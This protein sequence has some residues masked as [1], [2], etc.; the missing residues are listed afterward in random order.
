MR[1]VERLTGEVANALFCG[2]L[3]VVL[4]M[5]AG[6]ATGLLS[7]ARAERGA[8]YAVAYRP[9]GKVVASAGFDGVVRL[10]DAQTGK[11]LQ[12]FIPYPRKPSTLTTSVNQ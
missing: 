8:V 4:P 1:S 12:E 9:D 3:A 6:L 5:L 11:L 10:N 7:P 2:V